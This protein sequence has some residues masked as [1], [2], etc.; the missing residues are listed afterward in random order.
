MVQKCISRLNFDKCN[1]FAEK[2]F[3]EK[4]VITVNVWPDTLLY[5]CSIIFKDFFVCIKLNEI[6]LD[7]RITFA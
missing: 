2:I 4:K 5:S 7:I 3:K 6:L 1:A